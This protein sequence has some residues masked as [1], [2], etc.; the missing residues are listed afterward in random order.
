[1][2]AELPLIERLWERRSHSRTPLLVQ[3]YRDS[4]VYARASCSSRD[5]T[6][7]M[8]TRAVFQHSS[9]IHQVRLG[10][11]G[12][13]QR[14]C[15]SRRSRLRK[16]LGSDAGPERQLGGE[17]QFRVWERGCTEEQGGER[18]SL[19]RYSPAQSHHLA[20]GL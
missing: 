12:V 20:S 3:S 9:R 16:R 10:L 15:V 13:Q 8:D 2:G 11:S 18:G 7:L 19:L 1:M 6:D 17:R 5:M 4:R 14:G